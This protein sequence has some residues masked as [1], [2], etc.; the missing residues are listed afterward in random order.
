M[1]RELERLADDLEARQRDTRDAVRASQRA[2]RQRTGHDV[3]VRRERL[4]HVLRAAQ[5]APPGPARLAA[6][7]VACAA[8]PGATLRDVARALRA[9]W[10]RHRRF[11][12]PLYYDRNTSATKALGDAFAEVI[13]VDGGGTGTWCA[14]WPITEAARAEAEATEALWCERL[15]VAR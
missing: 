2:E 5:A 12:G 11:E 6:V 13:G 9:V 8:V 10:A 7:Q 14:R 4:S 15:G 3:A 1:I